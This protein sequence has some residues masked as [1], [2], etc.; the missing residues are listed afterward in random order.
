MH[1]SG[2]ALFAGFIDEMIKR[3]LLPTR[4][5]GG[6]ISPAI[7]IPTAKALI[8]RCPEY[9]LGDTDLDSSSWSKSLFK[10][11]GF[12][13]RMSTSGKVEIPEEA[14]TEYQ[15]VYLHDIVTIAE[16]HKVPSC[17]ILNLDQTPMKYNQSE[18]KA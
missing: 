7:V 15:L 10:W 11:M 13:K 1:S 18:D 16:E 12:V 8:D 14:K 4:S 17:L 2:T 5:K 3:Y 9:N 6:L